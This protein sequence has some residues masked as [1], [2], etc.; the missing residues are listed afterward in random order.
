MR[1]IRDQQRKAILKGAIYEKF[2]KKA[3]DASNEFSEIKELID[4]F[5]T[6]DITNKDLRRQDQA[7]QE[8]RDMTFKEASR[9]KEEHRVKMLAY[10]TKVSELTS[11]K[12]KAEK[13]SLFWD[14]AAQAAES[15]ATNRTLLLGRIKMATANLFALVNAKDTGSAALERINVTE[16][17]LDKIQV[18]ISD[19][20]D[21]VK[22]FEAE[23]VA[24]IA[25]K[26]SQ[27]SMGSKIS[28]STSRSS[29]RT[30]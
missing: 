27:T 1:A 29:T 26:E 4:R 18:F 11:K 2:L 19:L 23:I 24:N 16:R 9:V 7:C 13:E 17:Q 15:G 22:E 21:V 14:H 20:E 12:E 30:R 3:L 8:S 10:S 25:A 5:V 28:L 6:L